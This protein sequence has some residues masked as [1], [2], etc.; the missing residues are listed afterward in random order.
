M[1]TL[2]VSGFACAT[3]E[4]AVSATALP[5]PHIALL[6][7]MNSP[8]LGVAAE[9]VHQGVLA[10]ASLHNPPLPLRIYSDFDE[11]RTVMTAYKSAIANGAVAVIGPMTRGG[12][13]QLSEEK[14][15]PVP[16]L[17]L[18][19]IEGKIPPQLYLFGMAVDAEAKQIA[20]MARKQ[21]LNQAIVISSAN[22]PLARRLQFAFEEQWTASG[23]TVSR[24]IEFNGDTRIF[25]DVASGAENMVFFATDAEKA[26]TIR[27]YL[28]ANLAAYGTSQL[29]VDDQDKL[30][31][32][33][34]DGVHF[35]DMPWLLQT[36]QPAV[37]AYVRASP[38]FSNNEERLFALAID[39]YRLIRVLLANQTRTALP[40]D[41][42][43]GQIRLNGQI[44]QREAIPA[45]F[46]Q[47]HGQSADAP[48]T[49]A[50]QLFPDQF[51]STSQVSAAMPMSAGQPLRP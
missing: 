21:G 27:P 19:L 49:P 1:L 11:N 3:T 4:S 25:A 44:F 32:F 41:G 10:A 7:P 23:G 16:T 28:P 17:A 47:G 33:D 40:L 36:D 24:E 42:V 22:D 50:V 38:P 29:F 26:R 31:N 14:A 51:K 20:R 18:N 30:R 15:L 5:V 9:I 34:L 8:A 45:L 37:S 2:Y 39:A 6:L 35:I 13:R 46:V 43:T 12:V 48:V